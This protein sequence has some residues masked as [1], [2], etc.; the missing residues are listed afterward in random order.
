MTSKMNKNHDDSATLSFSSAHSP[1][2]LRRNQ[3]H[4]SATTS[5]IASNQLQ[6]SSSDDKEVIDNNN[7][8]DIELSDDEPDAI[9]VAKRIE[10][11]QQKI[12]TSKR[13]FE[14]ID[15]NN[16]LCQICL[17]VTNQNFEQQRCQ[18]TQSSRP[19]TSY[20]PE[21]L[22]ESQGN[23]SAA[24]PKQIKPEKKRELHESAIDCI[25]T[26]GRPFGDFRRLGMSTFF[27]GICPG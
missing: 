9:I 26:D 21:M 23:Q 13:L 18:P 10:Q 16:N 19:S 20:M 27:S 14:H 15:D 3:S 7:A 5:S 4:T 12:T 2:N 6:S 8:N 17:K 25:I 11:K 22:F 1:Y 24:N